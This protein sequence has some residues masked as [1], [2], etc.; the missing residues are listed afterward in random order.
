MNREIMKQAGFGADLELID[1]GLCPACLKAIGEFRD[2]LSRKEFGISGLCQQ[3]QDGVFDPEQSKPENQSRQEPRVTKVGLDGDVF[4][5]DKPYQMFSGQAAAAKF[6]YRKLVDAKGRVWL[7]P[8][9][10]DTPGEQVHVHDPRDLKSDGYGGATL[11][12]ALEDGSVYAAKGPWHTNTGAL[13]EATGVDLRN[14]HRTYGCVA[15][16]RVYKNHITEFHGILHADKV[17]VIG[18]F[19]RLKDIAQT[20]AD[21]LKHPVACYSESKGGTS[22][23]W[24]IPEGTEWRDWNDWF[25]AHSKVGEEGGE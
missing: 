20:W 3:C 23:G 19:N 25:E 9:N 11:Q 12:F 18:A 15:R 7:Y 6:V 2:A 24:E 14:T 1:K 21:Q 16:I 5:V 10:T 22:S 4:I 13:F 8:V 17:P